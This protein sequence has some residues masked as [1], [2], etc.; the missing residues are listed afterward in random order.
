ML[1]N[2]PA[3]A[4]DCSFKDFKPVFIADFVKRNKMKQPLPNAFWAG[5]NVV[6][7]QVHVLVNGDGVVQETCVDRN[8]G[9]SLGLITASRAAARKWTFK[10]LRKRKPVFQAPYVLSAIA[11]R[12][13][14]HQ[15][16]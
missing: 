3:L 13:V 6:L 15:E 7:I 2:L 4:Q 5:K 11:F 16:R 14:P 10:P 12:Y 9:L 1:A 8:D